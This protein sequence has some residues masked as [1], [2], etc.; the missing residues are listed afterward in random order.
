MV[1]GYVRL[2]DIVPIKSKSDII[3]T[4]NNLYNFNLSQLDGTEKIAFRSSDFKPQANISGKH[5]FITI[6]NLVND[7]I[8]NEERI[9]FRG[10]GIPLW[11]RYNG[12]EDPKLFNWR[13]NEWCLFARPNYNISKIIM[14]MI[15]LDTKEYIYLDDP[16]GRPHTKNWMPYIDGNN[17]YFIVDVNPLSVYKLIGS[18]LFPIHKEKIKIDQRVIHGGSNLI[19][20]DDR[21]VGIVHGMFELVPENWFYWHSVMSCNE[22]WTGQRVGRSFFFEREGIEFCLSLSRNNKEIS[23]PYSVNDNGV[24]IIKIEEE[25]FRN[26]L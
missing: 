15:N 22:D 20:I 1:N 10:Y 25:T 9:R 17:L 7:E 2:D 16:E 18:K 3:F 21:L 13:G 8:K 4:N 6:A 14:M 24:S 19:K 26:L 12:M 23:I 5:S 11:D